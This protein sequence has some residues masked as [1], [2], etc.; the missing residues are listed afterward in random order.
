MLSQ[1]KLSMMSSYTNIGCIASVAT[2]Q[3]HIQLVFTRLYT[4]SIMLMQVTFVVLFCIKMILKLMKTNFEQVC[5]S[6]HVLV[7]R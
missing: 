3:L 7:I 4:D 6:L 5:P 1:Q 2:M